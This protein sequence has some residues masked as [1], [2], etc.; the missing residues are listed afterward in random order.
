MQIKH[1]LIFYILFAFFINCENRKENVN[2]EIIEQ[3]VKSDTNLELK[4]VSHQFRL[5]IEDSLVYSK[6][7]HI[8]LNFI[9]SLKG[10]FN[11]FINIDLDIDESLNS[12]EG[13]KDLTSFNFIKK[14]NET[15]TIEGY[16]KKFNSFLYINVVDNISYTSSNGGQNKLSKDFLYWF[17]DNYAYTIPKPPVSFISFINPNDFR[18]E[19]YIY[20]YE[21]FLEDDLNYPVER[22]YILIKPNYNDDK[23]IVS[24]SFI[25]VKIQ[26]CSNLSI[27][28]LTNLISFHS[29]SKVL[30]TYIYNKPL[31]RLQDYWYFKTKVE[32]NDIYKNVPYLN[33]SSGG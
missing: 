15:K 12:L 8:R 23:E 11:N 20:L 3:Y 31:P 14:I 5:K 9:D 2:S 19:Y 27:K 1:I 33:I 32:I 25:D 7:K 13:L 10:T 4:N 26:G 24:V 18:T 6:I 28:E 16:G 21:H 22:F 29:N 30:Y 17:N